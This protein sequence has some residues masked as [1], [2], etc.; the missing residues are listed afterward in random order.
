MYVVYINLN[1]KTTMVMLVSHFYIYILL[2][3][4]NIY[5]F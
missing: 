2:A 4:F 5:I 3:K 1:N